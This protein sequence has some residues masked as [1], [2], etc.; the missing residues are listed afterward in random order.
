MDVWHLF[1]KVNARVRRVPKAVH[2]FVLVNDHY[3]TNLEQGCHREWPVVPCGV[4]GWEMVVV[5]AG[6]MRWW[7]WCMAGVLPATHTPF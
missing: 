7:W 6:G 3:H 4:L 2:V 5:Y 1:V